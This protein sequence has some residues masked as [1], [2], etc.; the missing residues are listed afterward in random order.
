LAWSD[1]FS[2]NHGSSLNIDRNPYIV[3]FSSLSPALV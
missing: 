2:M 1:L 3:V